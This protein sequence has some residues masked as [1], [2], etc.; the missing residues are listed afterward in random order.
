MN[1]RITTFHSKAKQFKVSLLLNTIFKYFTTAT[2]F[3]VD[4]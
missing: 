3:I 2:H 4:F 1:L